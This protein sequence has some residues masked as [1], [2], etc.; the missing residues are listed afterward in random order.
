[1]FTS[2]RVQDRPARHHPLPSS[3]TDSS[4]AVGSLLDLDDGWATAVPDGDLALAGRVLRLPCESVPVGPWSGPLPGHCVLVVAGV[5][6]A[7][8]GCR[9][10]RAGELL[11]RGDVLRPCAG[12]PAAAAPAWHVLEPVTLAAFVDGFWLAARR[13]PGLHVELQDRLVTRTERLVQHGAVLHLPR[14]ADRLHAVLVDL[15]ARFGRV[16]PDGVIVTLDLTHA[17]LGRLAG[18]QRPTVSLALAELREAGLVLPRDGGGWLLPAPGRP[19]APLR[20][21]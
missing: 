1:M 14:V 16:G 7:E 20:A 21:A 18:A 6:W 12:G 5:L 11:G 2:L 4:P 19:P 15:A 17:M 10:S 8:V 13:W 9:G 3:P